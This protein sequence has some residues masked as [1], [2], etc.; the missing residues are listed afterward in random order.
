MLKRKLR[1]GKTLLAAFLVF[2]MIAMILPVAAFAAGETVE[3]VRSI[4]IT[5]NTTQ[6]ELDAWAEGAAVIT[7]NPGES[8]TITLNKNISLAS[9]QNINFGQFDYTGSG[10][11]ASQPY[12]TLDL[13][14]HT[15]TGLSIVLTN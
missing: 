3:N 4:S 12:L 8:R 9:G 7:G 13:N 11:G 15:I 1:T 2:I 10:E 5:K 6:E 14:G